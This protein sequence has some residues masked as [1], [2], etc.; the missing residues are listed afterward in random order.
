AEIAVATASAYTPAAPILEAAGVEVIVEAA[1]P[2]AA[3]FPTATAPPLVK[4]HLASIFR[5]GTTALPERRRPR[6][7]W[8]F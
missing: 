5:V 7:S 4:T 6:S 3:K 2:A 1:A 8:A